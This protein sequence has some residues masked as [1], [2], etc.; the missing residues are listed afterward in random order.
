MSPENLKDAS[1]SRY[2]LL[3]VSLLGA[4]YCLLN[5]AGAELFCVTQGCK[6]YGDYR[7]F[8]LSFYFYGL[9]AFLLIFFLA[10]LHPRYPVRFLAIV[11]LMLVLFANTLFLI[12]Q[13]L[14][15][16]CVSCLIAAALI[17]L[18]ALIGWRCFRVRRR[19]PLAAVFVLWV[20]FF[21]LVSVNVGRDIA[22]TPWAIYGS[23]D[24]P[25]KVYFSPLCP[26]CRDA[27]LNLLDSPQA[28]TLTAFYPIA[29][30]ARDEVHVARFF[31]LQ[32]EGHDD[33]VALTAMFDEPDTAPPAL[34]KRER[35]RLFANKMALARMGASTVPQ[36]IS[37]FVLET[38]PP[39]QPFSPT[40]DP[41]FTPA[42]PALG[43]GAFEDTPDCD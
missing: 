19:S 28:A 29:K 34:G 6:I 27:V 30:S 21:I 35:L 5:A 40:F 32:E 41:F 25:I 23:D 15:W 26:A 7:L 8:G 17:G 43:C 4:V 13:F 37:P 16:P 2:A 24:A 12:Y 38:P 14:F 31:Q 33:R 3:T 1:W 39:G 9:A 22:F 10:L 18:A 20:V 42:P 11:V 36:I